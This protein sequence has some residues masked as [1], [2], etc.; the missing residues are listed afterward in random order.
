[1]NSRQVP[2]SLLE[3]G[4]HGSSHEFAYANFK[5]EEKQAVEAAEYGWHLK[6]DKTYEDDKKHGDVQVCQKLRD[7]LLASHVPEPQIQ[8]MIDGK[9]FIAPMHS[10]SL[11]PTES[12][13]IYSGWR[14]S[15]QVSKH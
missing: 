1:M 11:M 13:A 8:D 15:I 2:F 3:S 4:C 9:R 10:D 5:L 14:G 7:R 6:Q 12:K